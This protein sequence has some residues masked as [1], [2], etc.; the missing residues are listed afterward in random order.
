M[1]QPLSLLPTHI[2]RAAYESLQPDAHAWLP[3]MQVICQRHALPADAL[4][5]LS[6]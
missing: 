5:R 2:E 1:A 4:V 6:E 3:A